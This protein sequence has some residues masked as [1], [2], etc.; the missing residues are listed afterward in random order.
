MCILFKKNKKLNNLN[1]YKFFCKYIEYFWK[2]HANKKGNKGLI[3]LEWSR[4]FS[5]ELGKRLT[6]KLKWFENKRKEYQG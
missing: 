4:Y 5:T 1:I 2:D 3:D 6:S